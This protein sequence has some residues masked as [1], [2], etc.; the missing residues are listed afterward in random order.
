M[1]GLISSRRAG[2]WTQR[3]VPLPRC[4]D[5]FLRGRRVREGVRSWE[6][7]LLE[8]EGR[9]LLAYNTCLLARDLGSC[10]V[11]GT[12]AHLLAN[13]MASA[14]QV[15]QERNVR[16]QPSC[17]ALHPSQES[18]LPSEK[19]PSRGGR[20]PSGRNERPIEG[21]VKILRKRTPLEQECRRFMQ[22][23]GQSCMSQ[24]DP[25]CKRG[26]TQFR[27]FQSAA[28]CDSPL[29]IWFGEVKGQR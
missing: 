1:G 2:Q 20:P 13:L 16:R 19:A 10:R 8:R 27:S 18:K 9:P 24:G 7:D 6:K 26:S 3:G 23:M 17:R 25:P 22:Q 15:P 4:R 29:A 12:A 21:E 11:I 5:W 28:G 14:P